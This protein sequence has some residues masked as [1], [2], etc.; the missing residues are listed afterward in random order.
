MAL[1]F[2]AG[3]F[4]SCGTPQATTASTGADRTVITV[5][6]KPIT[7]QMVDQAITQASAAQGPMG[8][9]TPAAQAAMMASASIGNLI[10]RQAVV[11]LAERNGVVFSDEAIKAF[12]DAELKNSIQQFRAQLVEQKRLKPDA[13]EKELSDVIKEQ[14]GRSLEDIIAEQN[15]QLEETLK[16]PVR[17]SEL[18]AA[19]AE[20]MLVRRLAEKNLPSDE[21]IRTYYTEITARRVLL[22]PEAGKDTLAEA[23]R[24][25][26]EIRGGLSFQDAMNR[27]SRDL[28]EPNKRVSDSTVLVVGR[29][30]DEEPFKSLRTLKANDLSQP[31]TL[32]E[33]VAIYQIV[34]VDTKLPADFAKDPQKVKLQYAEIE[35]RTQVR[36]QIDELTR[37]NEVKFVDQAVHLLHR[38]TAD[39]VAGEKETEDKQL[40]KVID[41]IRE[42][43]KVASPAEIRILDMAFFV[44]ATKLY[45]SPRFATDRAAVRKQRIEAIEALLATSEDYQLRQDLLTMFEEEKNGEKITEN[46]I[47]MAKSINDPTERGQQQITELKNRM[48]GLQ[49][50]GFVK[51]DDVKVINGEFDRWTRDKAE[52]ERQQ[53]EQRRRD[54]EE[55]KR[56]EEEEKK[57]AAEEKAKGKT[58]PAP[59]PPTTTPPAGQ[60]K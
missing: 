7:A 52:F 17:R 10:T 5:A 28:P 50:A 25:L 14:A 34:R 3:A 46:L 20:P 9:A 44:A 42:R 35:A 40:Q 38:A 8:G 19:I 24:I 15:K 6:G 39:G 57:R 45:E 29:T 37:S 18:V 41:D 53:A 23:N 2:M 51:P 30:P 16:D 59:T 21:T 27:Y 22:K 11:V 32:P 58:N 26:T 1:V 56:A 54:A 60:P 36:R 55:A 13:T 43:K 47:A 49:A 12:V 31:I 33:G 4:Y 48:K